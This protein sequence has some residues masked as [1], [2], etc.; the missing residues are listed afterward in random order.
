MNTSEDIGRQG[1]SDPDD[2]E[3]IV[4]KKEILE[5]LKNVPGDDYSEKILILLPNIQRLSRLLSI[6]RYSIFS[7]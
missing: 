6:G 4:I 2:E 3:D 5:H 1:R 7:D